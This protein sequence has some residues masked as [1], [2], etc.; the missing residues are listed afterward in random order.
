MS[1]IYAALNNKQAEYQSPI[2][3][4]EGKIDND[5]ISI[6]IDYIAMHSYINSNILE[7]FHLQ[8]S[9]HKKSWLVQLTI[10]A[11]R[12][13]NELVKYFP[14]DI[15]GLKTKVDVNIIPL[16]S[17]D[18]LIGI[19]WLEKHHVF[20]DY[21]NKT[22]ICLDED[23][24]QGKIQIIL[25]VVVVREIS[26]MQLKKSF[27][28]G[29]QFVSSHMKEAVGDNVEIIEDHLVLKYFEDIFGEILGFPPK[30]DNDFSIYLMQ[31]DA[32]VSKTPYKMGTPE[33]KEL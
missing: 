33:L 24:Q 27:M 22:I 15:N 32:S 17:Y 1:S 7:I 10:G 29:C 19:D 8:R 30:R 9:K 12:N 23:G 31:G 5:P 11:K 28:K 4:V 16:G 21:Y 6:L 20:L 13:I 14:I 18:C 3:E 2:I 26:S 25:R